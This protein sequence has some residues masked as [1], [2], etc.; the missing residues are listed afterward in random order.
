[1]ITRICHTFEM[2]SSMSSSLC[3][4]QNQAYIWHQEKDVLAVQLLQSKKPTVEQGL[5]NIN[6][7]LS[8]LVGSCW[9]DIL[10]AASS[11]QQTQGIGG[12]KCKVSPHN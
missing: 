5:Q 3:W 11:Q 10:L 2:I 6:L 4:K 7:Q 9:A 1:M 12:A 8:A